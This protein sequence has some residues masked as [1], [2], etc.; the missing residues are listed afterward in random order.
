MEV[1]KADK[2]VE[3]LGRETLAAPAIASYDRYAEND[4][5]RVIMVRQGG[6]I[7]R[8]SDRED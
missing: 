3:V 2:L 4:R 6:R 1:Y 7:I 5:K 8:R